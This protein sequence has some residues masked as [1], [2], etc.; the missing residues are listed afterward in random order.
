MATLFNVV[1]QEAANTGTAAERK[2]DDELRR[3]A[4]AVMHLAQYCQE[5]EERL[6]TLET[7]R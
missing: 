3:L 7:V 6:R 2:G 4:T 1:R 5:L